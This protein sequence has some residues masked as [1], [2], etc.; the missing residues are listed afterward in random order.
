VSIKDDGIG[1]SSE[2]MKLLF[3]SFYTTKSVGKGTGLGLSIC[4]D[5]VQNHNGQIR[6]ESKPREGSIFIVLLPVGGE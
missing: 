5:I 6:V 3:Q 1:I 4:K 2:Q